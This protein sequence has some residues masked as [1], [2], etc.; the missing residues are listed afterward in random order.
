MVTAGLA[1]ET[2]TTDD[3]RR[4]YYRI[5]RAGREALAQ[6]ATRLRSALSAL[7]RKG[8]HPEVTT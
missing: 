2:G 7:R 1:E 3:E 4:R 8:V 5:T 6:E